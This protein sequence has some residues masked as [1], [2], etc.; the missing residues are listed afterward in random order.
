MLGANGRITAAQIGLGSR[1]YYERSMNLKPGLGRRS[2]LV[3]GDPEAARL[4][5]KRY[6]E[7]WCLP[8]V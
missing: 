1:G 8:A 6:G 7:P 2:K 3:P 4:M 5:T